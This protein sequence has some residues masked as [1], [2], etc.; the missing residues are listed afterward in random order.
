M[1][2]LGIFR[3][4]IAVGTL[5]TLFLGTIAYSNVGSHTLNGLQEQRAERLIKMTSI[6]N[7]PIS[8]V[9]AKVSNTEINNRE[10]V[11][12]SAQ[13]AEWKEWRFEAGNDWLSN[14][15][16]TFKNVSDRPLSAITIELFIIHPGLPA[17][18][19]VPLS[20]NRRIPLFL[21]REMEAAAKAANMETLLPKEEVTYSLRPATI[22]L[23]TAQLNR[24]G[25]SGPVKEV[26]LAPGRIQ[27]DYDTSWHDG[28]IFRRDAANPNQW[29][30]EKS[31]DTFD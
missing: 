24:A 16:F 8:L 10:R 5:S 29:R 14:L 4:L 12:A 11:T 30:P 19:S 3:R 22:D 21:D 7:A 2:S 23:I 31:R 27:F 15:Q 17:P 13:I 25:A 18:L 20:P 1:H 9:N 28:L 6:R 26:E